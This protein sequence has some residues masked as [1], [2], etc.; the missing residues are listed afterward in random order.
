M[1]GTESHY[2]ALCRYLQ[3]RPDKERIM[4]VAADAIRDESLLQALLQLMSGADDTLRWRAAWAVDKVS[5]LHP[6]SLVGWRR[7]M[8]EWAMSPDV[9]DGFRRLVLSSLYNLPD[10]EVLDVPFFNFLL[11]RM[12]DLQSPPG[13]QALCMKLAFRMS[14]ADGDLHEEFLCILRNMCM[15]YYSAGVVSVMRKCLKKQNKK[16]E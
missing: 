10:G 8:V 13:V 4:S 2:N 14:R 6:S 5:Q 9:A 3:S 12:A 15:E 1:S 16:Y 7:K 11:D